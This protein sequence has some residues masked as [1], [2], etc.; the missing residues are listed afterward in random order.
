MRRA[1]VT[2]GSGF[3]GQHLVAQLAAAGVQV[4]ALAR[5]PAAAQILRAAG[6][7]R[8]VEGDLSHRAVIEAGMRGADTVFHLAA[9]MF[10]AAGPASRF[11][12]VNVTGT[13]EL[14][15]C[16]QRTGASTFVLA[17]TEQVL[18]GGRAA[19]RMADET[20]PY[21]RRHLGPY[22]AS[23]AAAER[24][25]LAAD[26]ATIRAVAVRPRLVW[27]PGDA[28]GLGQLV[29]A[30]R[31]GRFAWI[32]GGRFATSTCHVGNAVEGMIA[33]AERGRAGQ[34]YFVT[35]GQPVQL[36]EFLTELL[37]TQAVPAP[38]REIPRGVALAVAAGFDVLRRAGLPRVPLDRA[39]VVLMGTEMTFTDAKA[40][41][42]LGYEARVSRQ[43]GLAELSAAAAAN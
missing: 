11:H 20:H 14:L 30:V 10:G 33:A 22:A 38:S 23:K 6:V 35:D 26:P 19:L 40:R 17:S 27:G 12:E 7:S 29:A 42:E 9:H 43:A 36:R 5:T 21:P 8:V 37:A 13:R 18:L 32:G 24:L 39:S 25:V 4:T 41:R 2:G 31:A 34:A 3:I 1:F 16:A 28:T 15:G